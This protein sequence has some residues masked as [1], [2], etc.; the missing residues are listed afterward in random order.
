MSDQL[1]HVI[2]WF[3]KHMNQ[4]VLIEKK[5]QDDLDTTRVQLEEIEFK[6]SSPGLD[7]YTEGRKLFLHGPGSII[8]EMGES[9]LPQ[10]TFEIPLDGLSH[11][12]TEQSRIVL[13]T[14]RAKYTIKLDM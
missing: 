5:E 1:Q 9:P 2:E 4:P 8:N 3:N 12:Q 6:E 11:V 13:E 7:E 14:E 10:S